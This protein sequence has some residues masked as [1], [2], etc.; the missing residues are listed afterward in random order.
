MTGTGKVTHIKTALQQALR[1]RNSIGNPLGSPPS[2]GD[3]S[4]TQWRLL[5][6]SKLC[7]MFYYHS[8]SLTLLPTTLSGL[9]LHSSSGGTKNLGHR[10][11]KEKKSCNNVEMKVEW[12]KDRSKEI[13]QVVMIQMRPKAYLNQD[14]SKWWNTTSFWLHHNF[15][16]KANRIY[17]WIRHVVWENKG[18]KDTDRV[19]NLRNQKSGTAI[20]W[21]GDNS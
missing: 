1:N 9:P 14:D 16:G 8:I 3:L 18:V 17:C 10:R 13:A 12:G 2:L 11:K 21:D 5:W 7:F 6:L 15:I 4:I 20:Y 19:Y